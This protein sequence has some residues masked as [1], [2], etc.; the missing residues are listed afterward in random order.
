MARR[1]RELRAVAWQV[2]SVYVRKRDGPARVE[3]AYRTLL[4]DR[5][6][7]SRELSDRKEQGDASGNLRAGVDR[8]PGA[9]ADH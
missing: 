1:P 9:R 4:E 3:Q 6:L 2:D 7:V 8:A 5:P